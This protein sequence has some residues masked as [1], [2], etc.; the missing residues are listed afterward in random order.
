M[1]YLLVISYGAEFRGTPELIESIHRWAEKAEVAGIRVHGN[2]L[3]P[4]PQVVT[5]RIR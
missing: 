3:A 2:P 4:P 1:K 5:I